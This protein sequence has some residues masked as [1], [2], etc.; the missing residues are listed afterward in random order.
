[1]QSAFY[2]S[3]GSGAASFIIPNENQPEYENLSNRSLLWVIV[4]AYNEASSIGGAVTSLRLEGYQVVVVDDGSIDVTADVAQRAGATVLQHCQNLGQGAALQTGITFCLRSKA[5]FICTFDADGQHCAE[6]V[7][8]MW[9]RLISQDF[10]I[11]LGSRFLGDSPGISSSRKLLLKIA[12]LF[13]RLHSGLKLTDA[14]NG[15]RLMRAEAASKLA[16]RHLGMA[17]ASEIVDRIAHLKLKYCEF[18]VTVLYTQY[19][20]AKGQSGSDSIRVVMDLIIGR[21][22][23]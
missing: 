6:D 23:R 13:T 7:Q 1:M 15:L 17:H 20:K 18:P 8:R 5:Q 19:S 10:D 2:D 11:V 12:V 22:M 14:H 16:L 21:M 4:P 9:N 3:M